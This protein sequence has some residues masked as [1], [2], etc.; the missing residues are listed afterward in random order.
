MIQWCAGCEK[1]V[2]YPRAHCPRCG[3][4][5]LEWSTCTGRGTVYSY[6][7]VAHGTDAYSDVTGYVLAYVELDE[8][9]RV[10]TNIVGCLPSEVSVDMRVIAEFHPTTGHS[11]LLRFRPES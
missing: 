1:M 5:N 6:T 7:T 9:P 4:S 8:G 11:A 10:L 2:W 3:S